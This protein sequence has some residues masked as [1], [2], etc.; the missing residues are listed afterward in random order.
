MEGCYPMFDIIMYV[1]RQYLTFYGT[2]II[3]IFLSSKSSEKLCGFNLIL[4]QGKAESCFSPVVVVMLSLLLLFQNIFLL[5]YSRFVSC[6]ASHAILERSRARRQQLAAR[7][8]VW[9]PN[10]CRSKNLLSSFLSC[11]FCRYRSVF[12]MI[13]HC[14]VIC[15]CTF[16]NLANT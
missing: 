4:V 11:R 12:R 16:N 10:R 5:G 6:C 8:L 1:Y 3:I 7:Q 14:N 2:E 9:I 13:C 15:S